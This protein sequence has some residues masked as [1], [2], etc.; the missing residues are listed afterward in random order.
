MHTVT[1]KP[2][3]NGYIHGQ[4]QEKA[5]VQGENY[6]FTVLT[7]ALIRMEYA[8]DGQ[9]EDRPTQS[10]WNR[11]FDVPHFRVIED[12]ET[13]QIVTEHVHLH[14]KKG[15]FSANTLW[16][17]V[18]GNYSAYH[19]RW[20]YGQ[21]VHTLK[22][23][24]RTLDGIDGEITLSEGILSKNGFGVIDDSK[25][26]LLTEDNW[27]KPRSK[28]TI[29][30][31][32]FGYGRNYLQALRDFYHLTGPTPLLPRQILGNWWSRYWRYDEQSYKEL[33]TRFQAEDIPFVV[34]VIDMDWH[35]TDIPEKYGSGWTGYT[36]N[37]ELFPNPKNFMEWLHG[38]NLWVTL[39]LHP[40][41]GV[42]AHEEMYEPMAQ[43]LGV[44]VDNQDPIEFDFSNPAFVEA[45]FKYLHHPQENDGVDFW[46]IDWQQ[47]STSKMEGLDP[48]WMLNHY[49]AVDLARD[50]KRPLIFSRYAGVGSHRYPIGFSG[51][52]VISWD[53]Y[54]YQP[55]FTATASNIGYSWWSHDIGG[56]FKGEKDDELSTRWVQYGVFSPIMRL[57]SSCSIFNGKEPWR[58]APEC[59]EVMKDYLRLRHE[60]VPYVYTMNEQTHTQGIPLIQPMYYPYPNE[61]R[62]YHQKNQYFFGSELMVCPITTKLHQKLHVAS[63]KVW[64]PEGQWFDFFN[65]TGYE[66]GKTMRVFR[67]LEHQPVFAK[68]GAIVPMARHIVGENS[69]DNPTQLDIVIFPGA[70]NTFALYEDNGIDMG[71]QEGQFAKTKMTLHW[72]EYAVFTIHPVVG[73]TKVVPASR[74]IRL[75]F[76]GIQ[77]MNGMI[78]TISGKQVPYQTCYDQATQTMTVEV[79]SMTPQDHMVVTFG[80]KGVQTTNGNKLDKVYRFLD[81]AEISFDLKDHLYRLIEE[82]TNVSTLMVELQALEVEKDLVDTLLEM[83]L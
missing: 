45:Y 30:L 28:G 19:S 21:E 2:L 40:A 52:T 83:V 76:R 11:C 3:Y 24:A 26:L 71:Y 77:E 27:V 13:L 39:N 14:Y 82:R 63:V 81:R 62:A 74:H 29:D 9:F 12:E 73:D 25:S 59:A 35:V 46:W 58:Y 5:M 79:G 1:R 44:N 47:G 20:V 78:V 68:A 57:H 67:G 36:W 22:G 34:S 23:T 42:R 16:I 18:R 61:E 33:M 4:A 10:V 43:A 69:V 8:E 66:G 38:K 50:G 17:D 60:L 55:Y 7:S 49:H 37:K 54:A 64:F 53:S 6:R 48:L 80:T 15:P 75:L 51:D 72:E 31:Y 65:G 70:D 41:D 56:H 32:L